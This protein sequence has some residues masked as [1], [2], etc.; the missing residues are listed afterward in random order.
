MGGVRGG[1]LSHRSVPLREPPVKLTMKKNTIELKVNEPVILP[2][3]QAILNLLEMYK[4]QNP[5]KYALKK[6]AGE[7]DKLLAGK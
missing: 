2:S 4:K 6:A 1:T 3:K 5:V 7:F